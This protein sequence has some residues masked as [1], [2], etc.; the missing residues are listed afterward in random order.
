MSNQSGF[1]DINKYDPHNSESKKPLLKLTSGR[2]VVDQCEPGEELNIPLCTGVGDQAPTCTGKFQGSDKFISLQGSTGDPRWVNKLGERDELKEIDCEVIFANSETKLKENCPSPCVYRGCAKAS[3]DYQNILGGKSLNITPPELERDKQYMLGGSKSTTMTSGGR[4]KARKIPD[5]W[6][7]LSDN[8]IISRWGAEIAGKRYSPAWRS[9]LKS[10]YSGFVPGETYLPE[11]ITCD[12]HPEATTCGW[13]PDEIDHRKSEIAFESYPLK[14]QEIQD[15][16]YTGPAREKG[17]ILYYNYELRGINNGPKVFENVHLKDEYHSWENS[18]CNA[19]GPGKYIEDEDVNQIETIADL[20]DDKPDNSDRNLSIPQ[21]RDEF[22]IQA[23]KLKRK[24]RVPNL[25]TRRV[26]RQAADW[27]ASVA[28]G[29][30]RKAEVCRWINSEHGIVPAKD[31]GGTYVVDTDWLDGDGVGCTQYEK[32]N[33]C[34][35]F[36]KKNQGISLVQGVL[37]M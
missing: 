35:N 6:R 13:N 36:V 33:M 18:R 22:A 16:D 37:K 30:D 8:Y 15:T 3:I 24:R 14:N 1:Y 23:D 27:A 2:T 9:A 4:Q 25:A 19:C 26:S 28:R 10:E 32:Q 21:T 17:D 12:V 7:S 20:Y 11:R 31:E 34:N 5:P 29:G